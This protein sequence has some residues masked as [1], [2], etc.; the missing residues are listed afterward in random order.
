MVHFKKHVSTTPPFYSGGKFPSQKPAI[1]K[2]VTLGSRWTDPLLGSEHMKRLDGTKL[3]EPGGQVGGTD[4][5]TQLGDVFFL[6][7]ENHPAAEPP[8]NKAET[9]YWILSHR[10]Q[11]DWYV[12]LPLVEFY[13]KCRKNIPLHGS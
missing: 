6:F 10:I 8:K 9:G 1:F 5:A 11:W 2:G 13:G 3:P 12:Y 7:G 4:Q